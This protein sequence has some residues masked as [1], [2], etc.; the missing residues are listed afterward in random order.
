MVTLAHILAAERV[1]SDV[2]AAS[3]KR[4]LQALGEVFAGADPALSA[5]GI[6]DRLVARERL[7]ST[8]LGE[9]CALPHARVPGLGRALAAFL[10]LRKGVDFDAPDHEPVD[11]VFALLVPEE[12]TEEHLEVL[13]AI[14]RVF[15]DERVR[16]SIRAA[17]EPARIREVL[18]SNGIFD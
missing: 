8:G 13:A 5:Q 6:F 12:S 4:T 9:G 3:R 16:S 11:L 1:R 15:A 17:E 10:R 2:P 14:A 18:L 7:G